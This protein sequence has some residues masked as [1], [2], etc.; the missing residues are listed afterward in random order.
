MFYSAETFLRE[1]LLLS[2]PEIP[3]HYVTSIVDTPSDSRSS[4]SFL[5]NTRSSLYT[6]DDHLFKRLQAD[7][8]LVLRFFRPY[9]AGLEE[10][11]SSPELSVR[12]SAVNFYLYANQQF[13]RQLAV[14][15]YWTTGLPPRRKKFIKVQWYNTEVARNIYI[16][17]GCIVIISSYHKSQWRIGTRPVARFLP[18]RIGNLLARYLIYIPSFLRF[19]YRC[20]QYVLYRGC[21]FYDEDGPWSPDRFGN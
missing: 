1:D 10:N 14:L 17:N 18:G 4:K 20:M 8:T 6:V 11:N 13:L 9:T 5:N 12:Q 21:L 16:L 2:L 3:V 15:I 19:L 7:P